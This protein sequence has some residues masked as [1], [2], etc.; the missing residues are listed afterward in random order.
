MSLQIQ[1]NKSDLKNLIKIDDISNIKS[2]NSGKDISPDDQVYIINTVNGDTTRKLL[3]Y[4]DLYKYLFSICQKIDKE[5]LDVGKITDNVYPKLKMENT[6]DEIEYQIVMCTSEMVLDHYDYP[7]IAIRILI[8]NLHSKTNDDYFD[9]VQQ[10]YNNVNVIGENAPIVR[11]DFY[12]YVQA[13]REEINAVIKYDRDYD[14]SIFGFRTLEKSYL[15]RTVKNDIIERPQ[16]LFMRVAIALHYRSGS[17]DKIIQTYDSLSTGLFT[18]ATPTLFNAGTTHEQLS[19][20]FLLGIADDMEE[21]GECWKNCAVISKYAGGIGVHATNIRCYGSYIRSTQGKSSGLHVLTVFDEI[22]RYADQGGKRA[23]SI[24]I[25]IEPWHGDVFYFLDLKKN[26][27]AETERARDLFLALM[28][29][30]I[31]MERVENDGIWSLMCPSEC[32]NLLNKY[33]DEFTRIYCQ[34]EN[35]GKFIKQIPARELW[36]RIMESQI[37]TGV[38]YIVFKDAVNKKSNQINIG[39]VNGSNLCAEIVEV[40]TANEYAVC[41]LASICLP[42]FVEYINNEPTYN[43]QKLYNIA[44]VVTRNLNNII[45][46]NFYPVEKTRVSNIKHRPIGV[47][48]QGLAD[49]FAMFRTAFDSDLARDLNKKIFET[50][51]FGALTESMI[52][53]KESGHYQTFQGSPLSQ[54]KFQF[55]LWGLDR[56]RL[57]GM[58]DWDELMSSIQLYGVSNSL[59]T[60]CMPTASTSQIM[61]NNECIEPYTEIIYTRTTMAGDYYVINK[62][63]MKDLIDLG[64]WNPDMVNL[65]KYYQGSIAN[66]SSIPD[67]IKLIYRTVWEIPQKSIIDMAADRG[68]FI[69]QTQSMNLFI[70][71]ASF[72]R[73]NSCLFHAWKSGLKTGMYYLRSKAAVGAATFGMDLAETNK[74][75]SQNAAQ[76]NTENVSQ[77]S[78]PICKIVPKHLRKPGD[79]NTCDG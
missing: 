4:N 45:D 39:V 25:Y 12:E 48:V 32:P 63:L 71:K 7:S 62:H 10:L 28:V 69:D 61:N 31:F 29:N 16:H 72:V 22:A 75:V 40:S 47:G 55:D 11:Q 52:I 3:S 73:L 43:Y 26:T 66:I 35:D 1:S 58:W 70:A 21:V 49:V 36:F 54:G 60:T 18:H 5:Y 14:I 65:I 50:I 57:S 8:N 46:I 19:S 51:Y 23:G 42:K 74:L 34:Y 17:F 6:L 27:G 67:H 56:S 37:E 77:V 53:A 33:G 13:H 68:P 41:N 79:C 24:V 20:C 44:R 2:V 9:V 30:D 78:V 64:S 38:P 59:V 76:N 15:K